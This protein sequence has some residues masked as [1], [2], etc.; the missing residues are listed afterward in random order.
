VPLAAL[1]TAQDQTDGGDGLR[2][3]LPLAGRSLI[4]YQVGLAVSAGAGHVVVLVERVPAALAQAVDRLRRQGWRIEIARSIADALDRF[5]PE[6]SIILVADGAVA[7]Q[8]AVDALAAQPAPALLALPD[9]QDYADFERIDATSRWAGFALL[10]KPALEATAQMLGD[11]D[12]TSTL[13]RRLVQADAARVSA[14]NPSGDAALAPPVLAT[15]PAV[16]HAIEARLLRQA[17]PGEGNWAELYLHRL[18][19][20]PLVPPLVARQIDQDH[21]AYAAA[22]LAWIAALFAGL[23]LFW[24][25]AALLPVAATI[26]SAARRMARIWSGTAAPSS[27]LTDLARHAAALATLILLSRMLVAEGGWGWWTVAALAPAALCGV[28]ALAPIV[29]AVR[30]RPAP[31]WLATPDALTWTAPLLAVLGGWRWM[32]AALA[33]YAMMS[34]AERFSA[35][36]KSARMCES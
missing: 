19:A 10:G 8:G 3:T 33:G 24:A 7:A 31:R 23:G 11:W 14:L 6:E 16:T 20:G 13:L 21:V 2:A 1:I 15:G 32:V 18:T 29:T 35:A 17:E 36:W 9:T 5:H 27:R 34:F 12:L 4:D 30:A 22:A 26:A 25:A 28:A